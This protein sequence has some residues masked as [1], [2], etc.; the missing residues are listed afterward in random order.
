ML[1]VSAA[2]TGDKQ[3][4]MAQLEKTIDGGPV[5]AAL[6]ENLAGISCAKRKKRWGGAKLLRELS[7]EY[8]GNSLYAAEYAKAMGRIIPAQM[9]P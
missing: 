9:H 3:L 4:G 6:C 7:E 8:P 5:L 1:L 2:S